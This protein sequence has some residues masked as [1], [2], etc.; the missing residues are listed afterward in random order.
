VVQNVV[1]VRQRATA[2]ALLLFVINLIALGFGPPFAGWLI[3]AFAQASFVAPDEEV[4]NL[5]F[6]TAGSLG[7][8]DFAIACP[9]GAAPTGASGELA[10]RCTQS[11][12]TGTRLGIVVT[13]GFH[14]WAA[15]HYYLASFG[16]ERELRLQ[17]T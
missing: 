13:Y 11:L 3:D 14:L 8:S 2:T 4:W 9:G 12:N 6:S 10:T 15:L 17:A 7:G 5:L 1:D 16:L